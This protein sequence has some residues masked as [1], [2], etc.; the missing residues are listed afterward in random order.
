[1]PYA[2]WPLPPQPETGFLALDLHGV[3]ALQSRGVQERKTPADLRVCPEFSLGSLS[4]M[5]A[6]RKPDGSS[7]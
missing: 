1:M 3:C 5:A 6:T 2:E 4:E 7:C